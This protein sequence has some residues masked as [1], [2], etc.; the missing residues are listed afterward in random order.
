VGDLWLGVRLLYLS[1]FS[2]FFHFWHF[3]KVEQKGRAIHAA[4]PELPGARAQQSLF[5]PGLLHD[6]FCLS[7]G[8]LIPLHFSYR[9]KRLAE[10]RNKALREGW[11]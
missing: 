6:L 11:G 3:P 5:T 4:P 10:A 1:F 2:L 8:R 7:L 9:A